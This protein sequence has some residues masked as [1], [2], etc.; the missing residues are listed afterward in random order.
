VGNHSCNDCLLAPFC[1][2]D[3]KEN[4]GDKGKAP[5]AEAD[6][7]E[8]EAGEEEEGEECEGAAAV[9]CQFLPLL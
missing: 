8:D 2:A 6:G 5:V 1:G 4:G 9:P 7:V 3:D